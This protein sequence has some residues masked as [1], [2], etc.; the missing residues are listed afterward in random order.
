VL[1]GADVAAGI[2]DLVECRGVVG[3]DL[4][5][6]PVDVERP[7][8]EIPRSSRTFGLTHSLLR[9]RSR[10]M[11]MAATTQECRTG[12]AV[13][14]KYLLLARG[15][16]NLL[17][18]LYILAS[19]QSATPR[20]GLYA[21]IDGLLALAI[22]VA[23]LRSRARWLFGL[24]LVD[25]L[26]RIGYGAML[27]ANPGIRRTIL[28]GALF[29]AGLIFLLI[30]LGI[31]GIAYVLLGKPSNVDSAQ[32][33]ALTGLALVISLFTLL[34]GV[35]FAFGILGAERLG[36]LGGYAVALGLA[37]GYAGLRVGRSDRLAPPPAA[38]LRH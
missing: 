1:A 30:A 27:L 18:G 17:F 2:E 31:V 11:T 13:T 23:L 5:Q 38:G 24:A 21:A 16:F 14:L 33:R 28:L 20:G 37:L 15:A 26:V 6:Q 9:Y 12:E 35:G 25:A 19:I 7:D 4:L 32:P 3:V 10:T 34:L 8:S 29:D 22:A 36:M